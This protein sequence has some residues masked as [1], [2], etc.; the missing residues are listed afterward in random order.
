MV[1]LPWVKIEPLEWVEVDKPIGVK[2]LERKLCA[3]LYLDTGN[4]DVP[5]YQRKITYLE[6]DILEYVKPKSRI[7]YETHVYLVEDNIHKYH[8]F[9]YLGVA[10]SYCESFEVEIIKRLTNV[11]LKG[12]NET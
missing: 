12:R 10:K 4:V 5:E 2:Y 8:T 3:K 1:F 9:I 7:T 6:C 11:Y